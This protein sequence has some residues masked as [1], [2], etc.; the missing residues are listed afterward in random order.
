MPAA[1][2]GRKL[3]PTPACARLPTLSVHAR[4][5]RALAVLAAPANASAGARARVVGE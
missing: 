3:G 4:A 5:M 2:V 1:A